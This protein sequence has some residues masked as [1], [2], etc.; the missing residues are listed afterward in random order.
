[1]PAR[2]VQR[3]LQR[4]VR[5]VRSAHAPRPV[6]IRMRHTEHT[7]KLTF[8]IVESRSIDTGMEGYR[9]VD[10]DVYSETPHL[11]LRTPWPARA[12]R[13]P[14]KLPSSERG[15]R[16]GHSTANAPLLFLSSSAPQWLPR[17]ASSSG[18]ARRGVRLHLLAVT[19]RPRR[20]HFSA[21]FGHPAGLLRFGRSR[22]RPVGVCGRLFFLA[23]FGDGV[24]SHRAPKQRHQA[25]LLVCFGVAGC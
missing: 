4:R 19:N 12:A 16:S 14:E 13:A 2:V 6:C 20:A 7:S 24:T 5:G 8:F 3:L 22:A 25:K 21:H 17:R 15:G 23:A 1:V 18:G 11:I 10:S 9:S